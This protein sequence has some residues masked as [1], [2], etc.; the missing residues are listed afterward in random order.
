MMSLDRPVP[1]D[2]AVVLNR[3]RENVLRIA[4]ALSQSGAEGQL[5]ST[6]S[7]GGAEVEGRKVLDLFREAAEKIRSQRREGSG[8][9]ATSATSGGGSA[10]AAGG[11]TAFGG[12]SEVVGPESA[13]PEFALVEVDPSAVDPA[14]IAV[15]GAAEALLPGA[16]FLATGPTVALAR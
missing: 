16:S 7:F 9:G 2:A 6:V 14:E 11:T 5:P 1:I 13:A 12:T 3:V 8:G 15:V 4:E 10:P